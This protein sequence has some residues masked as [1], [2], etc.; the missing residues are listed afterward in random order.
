[1]Y[2]HADTAEV[3]SGVAERACGAESS[4]KTVC[5]TRATPAFY[6]QRGFRSLTKALVSCSSSRKMFSGPRH[7]FYEYVLAREIKLHAAC[8]TIAKDAL[9][10]FF[11]ET[12]FY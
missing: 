6:L 12:I 11:Q 3:A 9:R 7:L 8:C 2:A 10:T 5:S 1:M 4:F